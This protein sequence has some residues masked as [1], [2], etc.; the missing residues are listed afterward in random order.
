[1]KLKIVIFY[2]YFYPGYKAGGPV[3]SLFNLSGLLGRECTVNVITTAY[4]INSSTP[5]AGI[6]INQWNK[7]RL[8]GSEKAI[9]VYYSDQS[10][11]KKRINCLIKELTTDVIYLNGMFSYKFFLLPLLTL[12]TIPYD[13]KIVISPRGMLKKGALSRKPLKKKVYLLYLQLTD[14]LNKAYWHA[15]SEEEAIDI[16]MHFPN[17]RGVV[18]APNIPKVPVA[19]INYQDKEQGK[20]RLAYLSLINEHKNVLLLLQLIH[21]SKKDI[22]LDI[23]G[24]VIDVKYWQQCKALINKM[25]GKVEYKGEVQPVNVQHVLSQYHAL[26]LLTKGENFG[27]ALYESLSVGRPVITS[28]FTPWNDLEQKKAGVNVDINDRNDCLKKLHDLAGLNQ[29]DYNTYCN[30]AHQLALQYYKNL[31][32]EERYRELFGEDGGRNCR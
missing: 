5:Y 14:L 18:V 30:G 31:D 29:E 22:F 24:P 12:K 19:N 23:Y 20:I 26:I 32:A 6:E 10:L 28:Y 27:H 3:Q 21:A 1:V 15:T 4:D 25:P 16:K 11:T 2:D 13:Y 8:P 17:N 7:V 9:N